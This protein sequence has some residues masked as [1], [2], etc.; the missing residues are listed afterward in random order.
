MDKS[1]NSYIKRLRVEALNHF[2]K[3]KFSQAKKIYLELIKLSDREIDALNNLGMIELHQENVLHAINFFSQSILINPDQS[4][5]KFNLGNCFLSLSRF[6]DALLNYDDAIELDPSFAEALNNR[7][8]ALQGLNKFDEALVAYSQAIGL[9]S[10]YFEALNNQA[11]VMV[12]LGMFDDALISYKKAVSLNPTDPEIYFNRAICLDHL[13]NYDDALHDCSR[14]INIDS[15]YA[16]AFF[17]RGVV[18]AHLLNIDEAIVDYDR[19]VELKPD[20]SRAYFNRGILRQGLKQF[21][22]ALID[23]DHV[24]AIEP[25]FVQT[26]LQRGSAFFELNWIDESVLSYKRA[27]ELDPECSQA[28]LSYGRLLHDLKRFDEAML[29]YLRLIELEPDKVVVLEVMIATKMMACDWDGYNEC[30][31]KIINHNE[32]AVIAF[33]YLALI[34]DPN[35]HKAASEAYVR[36]NFPPSNLLSDIARYPLHKRIRIGYFSN[37]FREHPV[38]YLTA[39]MFELHKRERFEV[40]AFSYGKSNK[41]PIRKRLEEAFDSFIDVRNKSDIDV[42][43]LAREME[44]DI[45]VD[46]TG[47]TKDSRTNIFAMRVAPIQISYIGYLGTMGAKYYDY[48]IADPVIIPRTH[49]HYYIEKIIYLP[50]YQVNDS[51][52]IISEKIFT[53]EEVGLPKEGFIF[54][55]FN[56]IYK[57]T[58]GVFDNWMRILIAVKGS[59]LLLLD[60]NET[61]TNNLKKEAAARGVGM[62]R[63]VFAKHLPSPEYIARY[64]IADLFLDTMPYNAG[65][66]ASDALR[67]GLPV[68]TQMGNSFA[69]RMAASLLKAAGLTELITT[70]QEDYEALAIEL[71]NN[72]SQLEII[73]SKLLK[74]LSTCELYNTKLFTQNIESA[75]QEIYERYQN[76]LQPDHIYIVN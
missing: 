14:A 56:N 60:A 11:N 75:Y 23:Y 66:T 4:I 72:P 46:L 33:N 65:T 57:I 45:A 43:K 12:E 71:A 39:E 69:S 50:C 1:Q 55:C 35:F 61:A 67:V 41:T 17:Q 44:I 38:S 48:L 30:L 26:Y 7:G 28:Y 3:R 36:E 70:N 31:K 74:N 49:Q 25:N 54:C 2:N 68:L 62:D 59:V 32:Q 22:E 47:F 5:I 6:E 27:I 76:D 16:E 58:P 15:E 40:I 53:R 19:A 24:L 13:G 9:K 63:I 29:N 73:K 37:D 21:N 18:N 10:N 64:R 51:K 34:D 8:S 42:V 20:Y 52:R